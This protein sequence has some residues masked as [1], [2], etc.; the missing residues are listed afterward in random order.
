[1][2]EEHAQKEFERYEAKRRRLEAAT[3]TSDF[4]RFLEQSKKLEG[5]GKKDLSEGAKAKRG[6]KGEIK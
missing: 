6:K 3:P 5:R 4:D 2:A 1:M